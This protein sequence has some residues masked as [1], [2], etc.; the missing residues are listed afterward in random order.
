MAKTI[1]KNSRANSTV[2][3]FIHYCGGEIKMV[4]IFQKGKM[5]NVARCEKCNAE[6]KRPRLMSLKQ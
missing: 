3:T 6:A 4:T 1:S 2:Q 5:K